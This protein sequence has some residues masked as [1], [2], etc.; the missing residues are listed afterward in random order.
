MLPRIIP[1]LSLDGSKLVKTIRFSKPNYLGDPINAVKIFNDKEVDEMVFLDIRAT[2]SGVKPRFDYI[3]EIAS[4]CFMPFGYGGGIATVDDAI[5]LIR[6]GAEK[7]IINSM[8]PDFEFVAKL[9]DKIGSQSVVVS[10]DTSLNSRGGHDLYIQSGTKKI[11]YSAVDFAK[12]VVDYGAG[13]LFLNAI[14]RDGTMQGYDLKIIQRIASAVSVPVVACGGASSLQDIKLALD[15]GA[16]A[17]ALGSMFVYHGR[18]RAVLISY[19]TQKEI[20]GLIE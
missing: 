2:I 5:K 16:S 15:C 18:N 11:D 8:S 4:E 7:V 20:R 17:V 1:C 19:P 13:E 6:N 14:D 9:A 12:L 10:L 3:K